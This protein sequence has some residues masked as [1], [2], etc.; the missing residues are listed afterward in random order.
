MKFSIIMPS[1]LGEY[2]NCA[3]DRDIKFK[4]AV[5]SVIKQ[6]F[7][8]WELIIISDGCHET[9]DIYKSDYIHLYPKVQ[10]IYIDKQ[11]GNFVGIVRQ[12]GIEISKGKYITYLDTDDYFN[13]DHLQKLEPQLKSYDWVY[14]DNFINGKIREIDYYR[15]T[16]SSVTHK[17]SLDVTWKGCNGYGQ[18]F[19]FAYQLY[20]NFPNHAKISYTGYVV[21]HTVGGVDL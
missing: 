3:K 5:D 20:K 4:R 19:N 15:M 14:Y 10:C 16:T 8:D 2:V 18:D 6:L 12:K 9:V 17:N 11:Q 21:C 1:Y 13:D 7:E